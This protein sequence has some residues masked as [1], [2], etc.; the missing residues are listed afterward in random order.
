MKVKPAPLNPNRYS[1]HFTER[2]RP[3]WDSFQIDENVLLESP[4]TFAS[5]DFSPLDSP[6]CNSN[7]ATPVDE[8]YKVTEAIKTTSPVIPHKPSH[9]AH[10]THSP[11]SKIIMEPEVQISVDVMS[12]ERKVAP[13]IRPTGLTLKLK[14]NHVTEILKSPK[15][16]CDTT[17]PTQRLLSSSMTSLKSATT[18][19]SQIFTPRTTSSLKMLNV[20]KQHIGEIQKSPGTP[21]VYGSAPALKISDSVFRDEPERIV[22]KKRE[23]FRDEKAPRTPDDKGIVLAN[24]ITVSSPR[25][26]V[27]FIESPRRSPQSKP[28]SPRNSNNSIL[29]KELNDELE[30]KNSEVMELRM[31]VEQM[32][33]QIVAQQLQLD[34]QV[35]K[36]TMR[37]SMSPTTH[38][39]L[40]RAIINN[41]SY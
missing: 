28:E 41:K 25:N 1:V 30:N 14:K 39:L 2:K 21:S 7:V 4:D 10:T 31:M 24:G 26:T 19:S 33:K 5:I 11:P 15:T 13:I 8:E 35:K 34:T 16:P 3:A 18:N 36:S 20:K 32:K 9:L 40:Q 27:T 12:I 29:L 17:I 38:S 22:L 37:S 23:S 6:L